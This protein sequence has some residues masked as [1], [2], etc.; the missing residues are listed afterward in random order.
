MPIPFPIT[1]FSGVPQTAPVFDNAT[2]NSA[3]GE[4]I[5]DTHTAAGLYRFVKITLSLSGAVTDLIFHYGVRHP[6]LIETKTTPAGKY[7]YV[8]GLINPAAGEQTVTAAWT[9]SRVARIITESFTGVNDTTAYDTVTTAS[10][11]GV[12]QALAAIASSTVKLVTDSVF[13]SGA[14]NTLTVG[15]GQTLR[16]EQTAGLAQKVATSTEPGAASITMSWSTDISV[17]WAQI[18]FNL[19]PV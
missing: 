17:D 13:I 7:I 3:T 19:L 18:G 1:F 12:A 9:T 14:G 8:Y 6:A 15:A 2:G 16:K 11:T 4:A 10:G 5:A